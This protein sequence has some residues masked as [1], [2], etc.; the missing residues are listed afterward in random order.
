MTFED[1]KA[2]TRPWTIRLEAAYAA[3]TELLEN[4]CNENEKS[5]QHFVVTD[6]DR[7]KSRGVKVPIEVL[8]KYVGTYEGKDP[9]RENRLVTFT[10]ML[11]GDQLTVT[12]TDGGG[13][14]LAAESETKFSAS[15]AP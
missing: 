2:Y 10:V 11:S 9:S 6:D 4:V 13:F 12:P 8:S 15:G 14:V 5:L 3:D 7:K 1:R